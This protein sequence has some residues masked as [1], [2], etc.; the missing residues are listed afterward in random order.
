MH[1]SAKALPYSRTSGI[2][3]E[4][5]EYMHTRSGKKVTRRETIRAARPGDAAGIARVHVDSS[6]TTYKGIY[7]D[8]YL[9]T[10]SYGQRDQS[11]QQILHDPAQVTFVAVDEAGTIVGFVNCG[12]GREGDLVYQGELCA[13]NLAQEVQRCGLGRCLVKELAKLL[14]ERHFASMMLSRSCEQSRV[15]SLRNT[16]RVGHQAETAPGWRN[17][18]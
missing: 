1:T 16:R 10:F 7:P 6:S 18:L 3:I 4:M 8:A 2:L 5:L 13:I 17:I 9:V 11:L 12:P 14:T 15:P